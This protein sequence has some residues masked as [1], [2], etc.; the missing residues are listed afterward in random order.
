MKRRKTLAERKETTKRKNRNHWSLH[1]SEIS[2]KR[3]EK[4]LSN[5]YYYQQ[6]TSNESLQFDTNN[7]DDHPT[8]HPEEDD[9][10]FISNNRAKINDSNIELSHSILPIKLSMIRMTRKLVIILTLMLILMIVIYNQ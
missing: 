1:R 6:L 2:A 3:N 4:K 8:F 10:E 7:I 9:L 5:N